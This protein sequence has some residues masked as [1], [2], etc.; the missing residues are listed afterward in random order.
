MVQ[1][2]VGGMTVLCFKPHNFWKHGRDFQTVPMENFYVFMG[3]QPIPYVAICKHY[4]VVQ[5]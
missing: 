5:D 1:Q 2:K 4:S 3:T